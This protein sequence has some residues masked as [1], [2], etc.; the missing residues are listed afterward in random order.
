MITRLLL[1]AFLFLS[2]ISL[3]GQTDAQNNEFLPDLDGILKTKF[4]FDLNNNLV[5]FEVRNARF[6]VKGKINKWFSYRAELDLSDE[7]IIKMLDAY[8]KYNPIPNLSLYMGQ[9]KVPFSSDYLRNPAENIFAN[10]SFLAKYI[11]EG[12][13]DIGF[14]A[15]YKINTAIPLELSFGAVNGTGNNNPQWIKKPN[16]VGRITA[17]S[18]EGIRLAGN[19]FTGEAGFENNLEMYGG[20]VRYVKGNF[21]IESEY[22]SR[23]WTDT[24]SARIKENGFYI[25]SWYNFKLKN[26]MLQ[27]LTPTARYDIMGTSYTGNGSDASRI[28]LGLNAGFEPKQFYAEIRLNYEKYLKRYLPIHTDKATVEF[29]GRF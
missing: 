1:P 18:D 5:R 14:Y 29:I 9:R 13:R 3:K 6:G 16:I 17:G 15:D 12:L 7:G 19:I 26:R 4:E 21:F 8:V 25:H 2:I 28:T 11:N 23:K 24:L 10:R 20:E 27:I 22:V